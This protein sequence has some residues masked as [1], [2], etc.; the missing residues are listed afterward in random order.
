MP[1]LP[2]LPCR[3]SLKEPDS[4]PGD[5]GDAVSGDL[6]LTDSALDLLGKSKIP[7][8]ITQINLTNV[9]TTTLEAQYC[10][11]KLIQ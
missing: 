10:I 4:G 5:A 8:Y 1:S 6:D 11:G 2:K 7:L 3:L 9:I